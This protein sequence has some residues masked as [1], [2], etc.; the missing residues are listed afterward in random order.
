MI[1]A[2]ED[3][4]EDEDEMDEDDAGDTGRKIK[5]IKLTCGFGDAAMAKYSVIPKNTQ[6]AGFF[7]FLSKEKECYTKIDN[8]YIICIPTGLP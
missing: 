8:E 2:D 7:K 1:D 4:S 5:K 6:P 3:M